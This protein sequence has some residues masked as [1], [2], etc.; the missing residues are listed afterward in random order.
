MFNHFFIY[1]SSM[2]VSDGS[3]IQQFDAVEKLASQSI[4]ENQTTLTN[5]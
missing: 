3:Q 1:S 2:N 4:D 5:G